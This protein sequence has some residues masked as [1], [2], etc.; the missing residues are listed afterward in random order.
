MALRIDKLFTRA[1]EIYDQTPDKF[2]I[3]RK[4]INGVQLSVLPARDQ[5]IF[6]SYSIGDDG[7]VEK[8]RA[9]KAKGIHK[10]YMCT[11]CPIEED[12]NA[13]VV[14]KEQNQLYVK[15]PAANAIHERYTGRSGVLYVI[16][17][18]V[19]QYY[20]NHLLFT[21][22]SHIPTYAVFF[23][24][25]V[26]T[27]LMY[28]LKEQTHAEPGL[29]G[30]FN[31]GFGSDIFHY[32]VHLTNQ[33]FEFVDNAVNKFKEPGLRWYSEDIVGSVVISDYNPDHLFEILSNN[34]VDYLMFMDRNRY[35]L[36]ANFLFRNGMYYVFLQITDRTKSVWKE[37][38]C[39][40]LLISPA[41]TL[42]ADCLQPPGSDYEFNEFV[43]AMKA[44]YNGYYLN[45]IDTFK[46][47]NKG[48]FNKRLAMWSRL[49][50]NFDSSTV[51]D[52]SIEMIW[53][54]VE[55]ISAQGR[56][57]QQDLVTLYNILAKMNCISA[58]LNNKLDGV[59]PPCTNENNGK[60][61]YLLGVLVNNIDKSFLDSSQFVDLRVKAE[62]LRFTD[63][64]A[65]YIRSRYL[66]FRGKFIQAIVSRTIRNFLHITGGPHAPSKGTRRRTQNQQVNDWL[67]YQ[68]KKI[69]AGG[70]GVVTTSGLNYVNVD[71][72]LKVMRTNTENL[73]KVFNHEFF[74]SMQVNDLRDTIPNFVR[75]F[76]GFF[77]NS[78]EDLGAM[79]NLGF[80]LNMSYLMLENVSPAQTYSSALATVKNPQD[81]VDSVY[82]MM[83]AL[84]IAYQRKHFT[85]YDLHVNNFM[86]YDFVNNPDFMKLFKVHPSDERIGAVLFKYYVTPNQIIW[87]P[88]KYLYVILDYGFTFVDGMPPNMM[89]FPAEAKKWGATSDKPNPMSDLYTVLISLLQQLLT[90][91][92]DVIIKN[93]V[94]ADNLLVTMFH[95]F[96]RAFSPMWINV[97]Q[98]IQDLPNVYIPNYGAAREYFSS[99][100]IQQLNYPHY[101]PEAFQFDKVGDDFSSSLKV[102][103]WLYQTY[104]SRIDYESLAEAPNTYVFNW[105]VLPDGVLMGVQPTELVNA[106]IEQ[107]KRVT[108]Q[109]SHVVRGFLGAIPREAVEVKV[110]SERDDWVRQARDRMQAMNESEAEREEARDAFKQYIIHLREK[111]NTL[112]R[113]KQIL[114][115]HPDRCFSNREHEMKNFTQAEKNAVKAECTRLFHSIE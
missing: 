98:F 99:A 70:Y 49:L 4:T 101:L 1:H 24:Y 65:G 59:T 103:N 3:S 62:F 14:S 89:H 37:N 85:H 61:K 48:V 32:H 11:L 109:R 15:K 29:L 91:N 56:I 26:F 77:C 28:F 105:G 52:M 68:F 64:S 81:I 27:D 96:L 87:V 72:V 43:Q 23:D 10:T 74:A 54:I 76:G 55:P 19:T 8:L 63:Y 40:H 92:R 7:D 115:Y 82:Q 71:F 67:N 20:Y 38:D 47:V 100:T 30:L 22:Q 102:V 107:E 86:E 41:F 34:L 13:V 95:A 45:F 53:Y 66:Y 25:K 93:G 39:S 78:S 46:S 97:E 44:H 84:A 31:G 113:K 6:S 57:R 106:Y 33:D 36:S 83:V 112:S 73:V 16:T 88:A 108:A 75:T 12:D 110:D 42:S 21:S 9:L 111:F 104:Y 90:S 2:Y 79:C 69:G 5:Y 17:G 50:T 51:N 94:W 114:M 60:F 80:G 35:V 18:T 58:N